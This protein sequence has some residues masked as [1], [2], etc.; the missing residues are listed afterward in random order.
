MFT[1]A[2]CAAVFRL[3]QSLFPSGKHKTVTTMSAGRPKSQKNFTTK[4]SQEAFIME[5]ASQA[6]Y[7]EVFNA[8]VSN[9]SGMPP[10]ITIIGSIWEP[11]EILVDFENITY[12]LNSL[13]KAI[14]V[15]MKAYHLFNIEYSPAARLMWQFINKYFYQLPGDTVYPAVHMLI[16]TIN[17]KT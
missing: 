1:D 13:V 9:E 3:L 11:Q 7:K 15:C 12:K 2:I 5:C 4:D 14:D 16:K 17:G 8:K 10:F 6:V